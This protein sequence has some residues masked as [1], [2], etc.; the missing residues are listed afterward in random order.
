MS[1]KDKKVVE[2]TTKVVEQPKKETPKVKKPEW[3]VKDRV[4]YLKGKKQPLTLRIPGKHTK[5]HSLLWFDP[6]K[7]KQ[8]EIR[9]ATNMA[10]PFADEQEGEVT[11]GHILFKDG[12]LTVPAKDIALQKLL[13]LYHPLKDKLYYE[14]KPSVIAVNELEEIEYEIDAL[15]AARTIDIDQAEAIMRV[16]LGSKVSSMSSKEIKRDLMLFAKKNPKLF[17]SLANDENVMLRN[18]AIRAEEN[19][20]IRLSQDQRTFIWGSNDRKL[21]NVPFDENPYSAFAAYLKTDEGVEVFK[22]IEKKLN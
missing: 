4:Y 13:S 14:F 11:L 15:N 9:Y 17:I 22:S 21:M 18:L 12:V 16:E 10:S 5:K 6:V 3:E 1:K 20:I 7:Q 19:G 2:E 8:R